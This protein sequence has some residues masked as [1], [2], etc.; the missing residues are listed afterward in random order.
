MLFDLSTLAIPESAEVQLKHPVTN[1]PLF[2][3]KEKTQ[4]VGI[5]LASKSSAEYREAIYALQQRY[6]ARKGKVATPEENKQESLEL[7]L[8]VSLK[9]INFAYDGKELAS[10][11][12]FKQ[13]YEDPKFY[14]VKDQVDEALGEVANFLKQ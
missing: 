13:L 6:L 5:Q 3:D 1:E 8:A 4:I 7:L 9:G 2:V 14:W 10:A 11:E 12:D